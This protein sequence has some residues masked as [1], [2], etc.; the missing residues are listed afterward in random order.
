[1]SVPIH[2]SGKVEGSVKEIVSM[3]TKLYISHH[4]SG[5]VASEEATREMCIRCRDLCFWVCTSSLF[6]KRKNHIAKEL[7]KVIVALH[8]SLEKYPQ[9][10]DHVSKT[11]HMVHDVVRLSNM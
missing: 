4:I 5:H 8:S 9:D 10:A 7:I 2:A 1:M 3:A 11:F 6:N